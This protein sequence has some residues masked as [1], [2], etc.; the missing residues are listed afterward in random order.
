MLKCGHQIICSR[1]FYLLRQYLSVGMVV[2]IL[3]FGLEFFW[4]FDVYL[5]LEVFFK[6]DYNCVFFRMFV[7]IWV[8]YSSAFDIIVFKKCMTKRRLGCE[9]NLFF[10]GISFHVYGLRFV[11]NNSAC[12][13]GIGENSWF[14][15]N[16]RVNPVVDGIVYAS[17]LRIMVQFIHF[18]VWLRG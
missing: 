9:N 1:H 14:F 10:N 15:R 8:T 17:T 13:C 2:F 4:I 16:N 7:C 5:D 3:V 18:A 11:S 12:R 6:S